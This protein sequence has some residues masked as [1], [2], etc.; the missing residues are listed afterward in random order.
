M[1]TPMGATFPIEGVAFPLTCLSTMK[2]RSIYILDER[3]WHY[4]RRSLPEGVVFGIRLS[5]NVTFN[6]DSLFVSQHLVDM[7]RR[8]L[9]RE[10]GATTSGDVTRER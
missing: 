5:H 10:V 2:T 7:R 6:M 3:R 9:L 1:V 4:Q 8:G